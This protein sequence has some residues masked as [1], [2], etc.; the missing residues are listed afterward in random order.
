[1]QSRVI[2]CTLSTKQN[3]DL[4]GRGRGLAREKGWDVPI[5][6]NHISLVIWLNQPIKNKNGLVAGS[7]TEMSWQSSLLAP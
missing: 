7:D 4:V 1:M 2:K 6:M 5:H 3:P